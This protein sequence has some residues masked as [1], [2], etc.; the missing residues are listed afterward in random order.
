[1]ITIRQHESYGYAPRTQHN[2]DQG[3]TLAFAVDFTTA[4]ERL[5]KK[6][7]GKKYVGIDINKMIAAPLKGVNQMVEKLIEYDTR[8]INVAG[9]GIYTWAKNGFDQKDVNAYVLDLIKKIDS[10]HP[11]EKIVSGGQTGTDLAGLIAACELGIS[12]VGTWP[13]GY[14]MR[15]E[16]GI[17]VSHTPTQ[18]MEI[19]RSYA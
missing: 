4:G 2:A 12:C 18:I 3:V 10:R 5:T 9:N 7:A 8:V 16:D 15:F 13:R 1:M 6:C 14:K 11:I 19:I 17:D